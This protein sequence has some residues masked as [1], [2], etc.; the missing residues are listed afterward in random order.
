MSLSEAEARR[1][2]GQTSRPRLFESFT[3]FCSLSLSLVEPP[4]EPESVSLA[5]LGLNRARG[6]E[7]ESFKTG[8]RFDPFGGGDQNPVGQTLTGSQA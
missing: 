7:P 6:V 3:P 2:R 8:V 1:R 4:F 5:K